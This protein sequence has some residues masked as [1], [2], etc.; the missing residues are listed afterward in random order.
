MRK[1][2]NTICSYTLC[3]CVCVSCF[4]HFPLFATLW[5]VAHQSP[6]VH[7]IL[8]ARIL[9]WVAISS[10]RRSS[11]PE[12]TSLPVAPP[13]ITEGKPAQELGVPGAWR[14]TMRGGNPGNEEGG[15]QSP[16]PDRPAPPS[17]RTTNCPGFVQE[18]CSAWSTRG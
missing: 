4:S 13:R 18:G 14:G 5:T 9:E 8:Q 12:L 1:R 2:I 10:S 15:R 6:L 3:V 17:A 11:R 7:G 16:G